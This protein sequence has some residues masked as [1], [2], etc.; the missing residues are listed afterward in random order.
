MTHAILPD[1]RA[2]VTDHRAGQLLP[3]SVDEQAAAAA[4]GAESGERVAG[5][6]VN[7]AE[8]RAK[9]D[10]RDG[11]AID[12][13]AA[14]EADLARPAG[15]DRPE[16]EDLT[17]ERAFTRTVEEGRRRLGRGVTAML[18][19]GFVGGLDIGT[20]VLALLLIERATGSVLLGG[21]GF[22]IAFV[23]LLLA[24]SELFTEGFLLPISAVVARKAR[25][26]SLLR[27]WGLTIVANLAGGWCVTWLIMVGYPELHET[28]RHAG[29]YYVDLG[30]T[31]RS[32]VLAILAGATMTLMT[33]MQTS[34]ESVPGKL[35]AA[36][37]VG[38]LLAGGQMFHSILDS[39][40]MFAALHAGGAGF[41]YLDWLGRF[42]W[43]ALGNI[44]GGVGL[45]TVLRLLQVPHRV[46]LERRRPEV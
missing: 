36:V 9:A 43:S 28:A 4:S 27:L 3:V 25:A 5:E 37:A 45:V 44:I 42:G 19:T 31:G 2:T 34:T 26:R 29:G 11:G 33:W 23:A 6:Q 35:A 39:L 13:G 38:F 15:E 16:R 14:A 20:G 24:R 1:A 18:T 12:D 32:F 10:S 46:A 22:S 7:D 40:L 30:Y 41:G 8:A 21:V 17:P